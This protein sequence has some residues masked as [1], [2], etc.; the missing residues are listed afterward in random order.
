MATRPAIS[1]VICDLDNTL[2]DWVTFFSNAFY[3]MVEVASTLLDVSTEL[4]LD[5][6]QTVHRR[7][8]NSEQPFALLETPS[9][10][11]RFPGATRRERFRVLDPAFHAFNS[12]RKQFLM[13]YP[14]VV[15]GLS[16]IAS[17]GV[18]VFGHT[19][20]TVVNAEFRLTKLGLAPYFSKL[21]ALEH[22]GEPHP[23]HEGPWP[24]SSA[25]PQTSALMLHQRKPDV[26]V[27]RGILSSVDLAP[28]RALYVGDS[29]SRDI[30]MANAAGVHSAW[31]KYGTQF[32][33]ADW[34]RLVRVTHWTEEDVRRARESESHGRN[35]TPEVTLHARFDEILDHFSFIAA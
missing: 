19:E 17:Q 26:G 9:V 27:L 15:A 3:A 21:Y 12:A 2:Y 13:P 8:H 30:A 23:D 11:R 1:L 5:E 20:A 35:A 6:L 24:R 7:Y 32:Q 18:L 28:A 14:G 31:A 34:D 4:L 25:S 10:Q 29:L 33:R 22:V 16:K